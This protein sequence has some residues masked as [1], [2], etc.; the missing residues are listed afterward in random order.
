[1]KKPKPWSNGYEALETLDS[2]GNGVISGEELAPLALWFD[3]NR[4]AQ[5]QEG[6]VRDIRSTG[7]I[8]LAVGPQKRDSMTRD[9]SVDKGFERLVDGRIETGRTIDWFSDGAPTMQQLVLADQMRLPDSLGR[10]TESESDSE[11]RGDDNETLHRLPD[12]ADPRRDYASDSK[13]SGVWVWGSKDQTNLSSHQGLIAIRERKNGQVEVMTV[14]EIGV[15]DSAGVTRA[16]QKYYLMTGSVTKG[17]DGSIKISFKDPNKNTSESV[18][19]LDERSGVLRGETTQRV[20]EVKG[21][22]SIKYSWEARKALR[23]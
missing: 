23:Q 1:M 11:E 6:E 18:A 10:S 15:R 14:G 4:D 16:L 3:E 19:I 7:V 20:A 8:S 2:D 12:F 13:I 21:T 5:A 22:T 9:V 17:A